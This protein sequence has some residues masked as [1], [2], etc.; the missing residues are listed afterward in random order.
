MSCDTRSFIML[1]YG[2]I[3]FFFFFFFFELLEVAAIID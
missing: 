3:I 1:L 2:F